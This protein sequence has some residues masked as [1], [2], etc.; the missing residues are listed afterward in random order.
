MARQFIAHHDQ[1]LI[2][3]LKISMTPGGVALP[4]FEED[5]TSEIKV[6]TGTVRYVG[7][8]PLADDGT[9]VPCQ[10]VAGQEV[11]YYVLPSRARKRVING[12]ELDI[13][14]DNDVVGHYDAV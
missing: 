7:P 11:E 14:R 1:V 12:V 4:E 3:H 13:V 10:C 9:R 6:K 8:G 2:E 5:A